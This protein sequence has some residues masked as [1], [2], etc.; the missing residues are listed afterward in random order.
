MKIKAYRP[1]KEGT[2]HGPW[3]V[4]RAGQ[5]VAH[6]FAVAV[7]GESWVYK[8]HTDEAEARRLIEAER[9]KIFQP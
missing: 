7:P 3:R 9:D 1:P 6:Q 4:C 8:E 2:I 5:T